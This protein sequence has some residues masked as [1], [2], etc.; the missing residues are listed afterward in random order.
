MT[1]NGPCETCGKIA[2]FYTYAEPVGWY[3]DEHIPAS[4]DVVQQLKEREAR[5]PMNRRERRAAARLM[6]KKGI[7]W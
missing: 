2:T 3:C 1:A 7:K 6:A 4:I 5:E